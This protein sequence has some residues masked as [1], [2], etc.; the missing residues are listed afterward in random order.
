ME[1]DSFRLTLFEHSKR[2]TRS[3]PAVAITRL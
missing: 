3:V 1:A 2:Q